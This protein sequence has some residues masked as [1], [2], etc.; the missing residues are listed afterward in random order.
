MRTAAGEDGRVYRVVAVPSEGA[1][2]FALVL[3]QSTAGTEAVLQRLGLVLLFVGGAGVVI[4]AWAGMAIARTGLRP[5]QRL[6]A[7]AEHVA[8]T[9]DL[10][11]VPVQGS[12]ELA[13]LAHS[14]NAML[15]ALAAAR[16]RERR[17]IA[18]A[19]HELRTPLTSLRTNLDLL[20]QSEDRPGLSPD[21]RMALLH[22]V[23]AQ[24][25]ELSALVGDLV[26]LSREDPPA[27]AHVPVDLA[28]IVSHAVERVRRRAP[29][30]RFDVDAQP[31]T[32]FGDA[33][34]LE[35]AV[36]NLL[37]NGAKW[38]PP[39]GVVTV[40]LRAGVLRSRIRVR[41]SPKSTSRTCSTASTGRPKPGQCPARGSACPS[42]SRPPTGMVAAFA[43]GRLQAAV[44]S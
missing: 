43:R 41:A 15:S 44:R 28:D 20:A 18:D 36:T 10:R 40:S 12:D 21:D 31:W 19:G 34:A 23:R 5:V 35:R 30:V 14:F 37:D 24:V 39:G 22:D 6:T 13:R 27:A 3:G 29:G 38:S 11:P 25:F 32:V 42:S 7:A 1:P 16:G 4:A 17:L 33:Q 8:R 26:E 9:G 2:G